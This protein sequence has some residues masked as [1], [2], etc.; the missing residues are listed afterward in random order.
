MSFLVGD[1]NEYVH[2]WHWVRFCLPAGERTAGTIAINS[3]C[4]NEV[5][6]GTPFIRKWNSNYPIDSSFHLNQELPAPCHFMVKGVTFMFG[7]ECN[8]KDRGRLKDRYIYQLWIN[9]KWYHQGPMRMFPLIIDV[10]KW[11]NVHIPELE[12]PWIDTWDKPE[13]I[14]SQCSL[15]ICIYGKPFIPVE[16]I[17]VVVG[18]V[19]DYV[20]SIQ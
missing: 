8:D 19:G 6:P 16:D 12:L 20:R 1:M 2:T 17:D 5:I 15:G 18:M 10:S 4:E 9:Q 14:L 3:V 13:I 7:N 11:P